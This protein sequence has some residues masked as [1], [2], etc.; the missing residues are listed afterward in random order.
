MKKTLALTALALAF[1]ASSAANAAS[2]TFTGN[3]TNQGDVDTYNF[4]VTSTSN[5]SIWTDSFNSGANF[6]P[7]LRIF[8]SAGALIAF[9][10]DNSGVASGQTYWD[11]GIVS[12]L[13]AD[14]YTVAISVCCN[15]YSNS[16]INAVGANTPLT[17]GSFYR[18]NINGNS[19]AAATSAVPVP[20]AAWLFGTGLVGLAG[21]RRKVAA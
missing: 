1:A 2:L 4:T 17:R 10:D 9:N 12:T 20:A 7:N 11:S 16:N 3:L 21:L 13:A 19:V 6:D 15:L 18:I 14:T 5:V 8:N